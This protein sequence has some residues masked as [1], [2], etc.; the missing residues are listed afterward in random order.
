MLRK[1]IGADYSRMTIIGQAASK[2]FTI[3]RNLGASSSATV[4]ENEPQAQAA[5]ME[6]AAGVES[7]AAKHCISEP[8]KK[9]LK[10]GAEIVDV[11]ISRLGLTAPADVAEE[12][13][14][15]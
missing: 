4:F 6:F 10:N 13:A 2:S 9:N 5:V 1:C 7:A 3:G 8:L 12:K 14:G 15:M 11:T